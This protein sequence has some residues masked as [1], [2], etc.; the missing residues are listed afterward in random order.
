MAQQQAEVKHVAGSPV[1][2]VEYADLANPEADLSASIREAYG[3]EGLGLLAVRGVPGVADKREALLPLAY[4]FANMPAEV[5]KKYEHKESA[6]NFGWSCGVEMLDG[7]PDT[8]K[9]SF[10]NNPLHDDPF[11]GDEAMLA[12]CPSIAHKNVWPT[13][14][15]PELEAAFKAVGRVV[16]DTGVLLA[17]H[18]DKYARQVRPAYKE[19]RLASIIRD[20]V[21]PKGRLL[22]YFPTDGAADDSADDDGKPLDESAYGTWCG[23]HNDNGSLTGLIPAMYHAA[24]GSQ[25]SSP[26]PRAGLYIRSRSGEIIKA[27]LPADCIGFQIGE[28]AQIHSGGALQATPHCVRAA[29]GPKCAGIARSTFALFMQPMLEEEMDVPAGATRED[30]TAG[31][32]QKHL[33]RGVPPLG[34]RWADGDDFGGFCKKTIDAYLVE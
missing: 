34:D 6:Y 23:W 11:K 7:V 8:A 28:S 10:Y 25:T 26:D 2:L 12:K 19:G 22:H 30:A 31:A 33:P 3:Y 29:R 4:R 16:V 32:I 13:E 20:S 5:K 18:C 21:T 15:L 27:A 17:A 24:D 1:V 9:G 14:E